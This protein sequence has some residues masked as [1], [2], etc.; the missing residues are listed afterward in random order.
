MRHLH[1][2]HGLV[3]EHRLDRKSL[4]PHDGVLVMLVFLDRFGMQNVFFEML[5]DV[6]PR[7]V[8]SH[9][10]RFVLPHLARHLVGDR[11]DRGVHVIGFFAGFDGD[12]VRADQNDFRGVPVFF[13][14]ENDVRFDDLRVIEMQILD[15]AR[16]IIVDRVRDR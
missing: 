16:A 5:D 12:V 6:F 8:F 1:L 4:R 9:Q 14:F 10:T 2:E 11:I 15:L 7:P 13:H 3:H